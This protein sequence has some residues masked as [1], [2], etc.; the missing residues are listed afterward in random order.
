MG[1]T[2]CTEPQCLYKGALYLYLIIIFLFFFLRCLA[3]YLL[4]PLR[5]TM[6]LWHCVLLFYLDGVIFW[7][8]KL[9]LTSVRVWWH[10][11]RIIV[12]QG[13]KPS[14]SFVSWHRSW[15]SWRWPWLVIGWRTPS[16]R[17]PSSEPSVSRMT[18]MSASRVTS[19]VSIILVPTMR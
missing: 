14:H 19:W 10:C 16:W 17:Q 5:N 18:P 15:T 11:R 3:A 6:F 9:F 7:E 13:H 12:I 8:W 2:A 1:R 4:V